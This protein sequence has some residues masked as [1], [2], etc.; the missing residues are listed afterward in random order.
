MI[1]LHAVNSTASKNLKKKI[2]LVGT[3]ELWERSQK[4]EHIWIGVGATFY[5]CCIRYSG[6]GIKNLFAE[7][8]RLE[9]TPPPLQD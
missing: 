5:I 4:E 3:V 7:S 8:V 2:Y 1:P 6:E 9:G